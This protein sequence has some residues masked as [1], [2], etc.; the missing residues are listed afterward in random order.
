M[1]VLFVDID[2]V[3]NSYSNSELINE[4]MVKSIKYNL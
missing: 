1:N 2:G 4:R 3:L